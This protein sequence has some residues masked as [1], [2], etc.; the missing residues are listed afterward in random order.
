VND[1]RPCAATPGE[2]PDEVYRVLIE[3]ARVGV[4]VTQE[5]RLLYV[6]TNLTE[7]FGY[8]R[9]E[10]LSGMDPLLMTAPGD[11]ARVREQV[12]HR[13]AGRPSA[14]YD[15]Q[16]VRKDGSLF[17]ARVFGAVVQLLGRAAH[18]VTLHDISELQQA[19]RSAEQRNRLLAQTEE[20]A[21][22]GS[23]EYD[24]A[25]GVAKQSAGM[26]KIFGEPV[27]DAAVPGQWLMERLPASEQASVSAILESV[28]PQHPCEFEHRI[29]HTDGFLRTVLHRAIAEVDDHGRTT[30]VVGILQDITAQRAA[31]Q[32]LDLLSNTDEV[33]G[34]PNRA[35]FLDHL[36]QVLRQAQRDGERI[37]L[38]V[39]QIDQLALVGESLGYAGADKLLALVGERLKQGADGSHLA[40]LGSGEFALVLNAEDGPA[41][42]LALPAAQTVVEAFATLFQVEAAEVKVS[43][44]MGSSFFPQDSDSAPQLL[45]QAQ[46]A[47]HR[48]H[49]LGDN[50]VCAYTPNVHGKAAARLAMEAGLRRA[51]ARHEFFLYYQP[52]LD[53]ATGAVIGVE[54]LLRW[55]DA[56]AGPVS[57]AEFIPLAEETGLILPIGE[58]V[59]R[60]ACEQNLAWQ[61]AG[62]API[63]VAVNLSLRQLQQPDI[64]RRIQAILHETRMEPQHLGLEITE[65]LLMQESAHVARMLGEIKALGVEI[66]LDDFGTGYS[67]LNYLRSLPIDVVKVDRSFV[68]DVTAALHDVSMTRAVITMAHSL[69]MKVLAEGV[70]TESQLSLLI[71]NKCDQMQG[72]FF[73]PPVS[74]QAIAEMLRERKQLPAHLLQRRARKR[75]LLLVDDEENIVAAL[76]RL[77]RRDG[78]HVVTACNGPQ[79]LQRLAEH[80]VDVILSDQRMPGMTGV[81]FLRRAKELYPDTV[82]MVLSGYTE[83]TSITDAINEGAIYKFLTKPWDDE[84]LRVHI[85]EAFKHKEMADENRRLGSAVQAANDELAQVNERLQKILKAQHEQINREEVSLE[86]A[87]EVLENIPAPVIGFD[88]EGMI[89]YLNADA[90]RLFA[91]EPSLLGRWA[92]DALPAGLVRVWQ[93]GDGEHHGVDVLGHSFQAVCRTLDKGSRS[94]GKLLLL[95]PALITT[96]RTTPRSTPRTTSSTTS[97]PTLAD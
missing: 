96:P 8:S 9:A 67:N 78:Y 89:A 56:E 90:E 35:A 21:R 48:A 40:H 79:G 25:S 36:D 3:Q 83:L 62:L 80:E 93:A 64:A 15:V 88:I 43:C 94:A 14:A 31:E 5:N 74:A 17:D 27:S 60:T 45:Q 11:R 16:C 76:K 61:R 39:L 19:L 59:L 13:A 75:T 50:H 4:F 51:L 10:M 91:Q 87:R 82:R 34:L 54:A 72:Y 7:L 29:V 69:Q 37:V 58:W 55:N 57:P 71:A 85:E 52:Q 70:E 49:E 84:R 81:E 97:S 1:D 95:S 23:S 53:L 42:E 41:D 92:E 24:I 47:R 28:Q 68:H 63:R 32:R 20:L 6:N 22:I 66:S 26:F 2:L 18:V 30:R 73:S 12:R 33:T 46:A 38:L 44:S 65:G 77:V 86:I